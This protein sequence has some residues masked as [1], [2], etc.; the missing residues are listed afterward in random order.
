MKRWVNIFFLLFVL[1]LVSK[2][3]SFW[4]Q[5]ANC[6]FGSF[7][8]GF[9]FSHGNK[10]FVAKPNNTPNDSIIYYNKTTNTWHYLGLFPGAAKFSS[11]IVYNNKAIVISGLVTGTT[12]TNQ[13][14]EYD[15]PNNLWTQKGGF[16]GV[17]VV[18]HSLT[19]NPGNNKIYIT[20]GKTSV[21][22]TNTAWTLDPV[23]YT[24]A[25]IPSY[26]AS[27]NGARAYH[28]SYCIGG[29]VYVYSGETG[30]PTMFTTNNIGVY[31]P[32]SGSWTAG[33]NA[34]PLRK[35]A[36]AVQV[37]TG[38][39]GGM[40]YFGGTPPLVN[41]TDFS[42]INPSASVP[43]FP[44]TPF[45]GA[46][47]VECQ[48]SGFVG[49]GFNTT[50]SSTL[51]LNVN[52]SLSQLWEFRPDLYVTPD[53][54]NLLP[55]A[56]GT[57]SP[58]ANDGDYF[59]GLSL[60]T[61]TV[62]IGPQN[63]SYSLNSSTGVI[64]YT[65]NLNFNGK[66]SIKYT[67]CNTQIPTPV[68]ASTWIYLNIG[69]TSTLQVAASN[70]T[71]CAGAS[72]TLSGTGAT[73]YTWSPSGSNNAAIVVSPTITS[74]YTVS[75]LTGAVV[76]TKTITITVTPLPL[77]NAST[78]SSIICLGATTTLTA[79]GASTYTWL[80]SNVTTNTLVVM[81][82]VNTTYSLQG[83]NGSCI[84][85]T[86]IAITV[87]TAPSPSISASS[88]IVCAGVNSTLTA[89][90]AST[91]TWLPSNTTTNTLVVTPTVSTTYSLLGSNTACSSFTS[92]VV[93]VTTV[94][95]LT[96]AASSTALCAG[97]SSTLSVSGASTYTW[98][99]TNAN[100]SFIVVNPNT[101]TTYTVIGKTGT[102]CQFQ[103]IITL[104]VTPYP[105]LSISATP[106]LIMAGGSSTLSC[107]GSS[108][109]LWYP[110]GLSGSSIVVTPNISTTYTV[111]G[112]NPPGCT[113]VGV[114]SVLVSVGLNE[115]NNSNDEFKIYPT[116]TSSQLFIQTTTSNPYTIIFTNALGQEV[117]HQTYKGSAILE[118]DSL[119]KGL[120]YCTIFTESQTRLV[121]KIIKN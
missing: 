58:L 1:T 78:S 6:T 2:A 94:P 57:I 83:I 76:Q 92:I 115:I 42:R 45:S 105:V 103:K 71:I 77:I 10:I 90:G 36:S 46:L 14:W 17:G 3:Q 40:G 113:N 69:A 49:L 80:P 93:T 52:T 39:Y 18:G 9:Y 75:G 119:S 96:T 56:T 114:V 4:V 97:N 21:T 117:L 116:I 84:S 95:S 55:N 67:I 13:V 12:T 48:G 24:Y 54:L 59:Y 101:T 27:I 8:P 7:I 50:Y 108:S 99:P 28:V 30:S 70:L 118:I 87:T 63:G 29:L 38:V 60:P 61:L 35:S 81:P 51:G 33:S 112:T 68:C 11:A 106:S 72:T 53:T 74:T 16:P 104:S 43:A 25:S 31:S 110:G 73:S 82:T 120:Y 44:G 5:R 66:D 109:A 20:F 22:Y 86:T 79:N 100:T 64:S 62:N 34:G 102:N 47:A 98:L 121:K 23:T 19:F 85:F 37:G 26:T 41:N 91:Y 89:S 107:L 111:Y 15:I 32:I 88:N 65:P